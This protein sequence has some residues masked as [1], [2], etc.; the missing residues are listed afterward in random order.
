MTSL[1]ME[2]AQVQHTELSSK[3]ISVYDLLADPAQDIPQ[4]Q[5][6]C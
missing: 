2:A 3:I 1:G 6:P 4:Y 5:R